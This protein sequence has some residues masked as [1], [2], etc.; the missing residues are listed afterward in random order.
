M[1][2]SLS[3]SI[4]FRELAFHGF[5]EDL[6][7]FIDVSLKKINKSNQYMLKTKKISHDVLKELWFIAGRLLDEVCID[8]TPPPAYT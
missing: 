8:R 2:S 6:N 3:S 4:S 1:P 7:L 5:D